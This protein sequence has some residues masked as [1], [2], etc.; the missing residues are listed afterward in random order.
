MKDY[1][2]SE[3]RKEVMTILHLI[4]EGQYLIDGN[5]LTNAEKGDIRRGFSFTKKAIESLKNRLNEDAKKSL[6]KDARK[7]R[8]YLDVCSATEEYARKKR[9]EI[10]AAYEENKDYY[11]LVELILYYNC[12]NCKKHCTECEIYKEFEEHRIPEFSGAKNTGNCR[13]SYEE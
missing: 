13:Y 7:S 12:K 2:N 3:E 1:L 9:S 11:R 6:S 10:D 4:S 5:T 8:V